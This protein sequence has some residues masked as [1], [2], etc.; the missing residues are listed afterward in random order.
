MEGISW[1]V[2][3]LRLQAPNEGDMDSTPGWGTEIVHAT[4]QKEN[5]LKIR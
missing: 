4:W 3:W 1:V 2:Q 5:F